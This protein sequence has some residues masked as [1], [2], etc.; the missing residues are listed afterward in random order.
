[1]SGLVGY[2]TLGTHQLRMTGMQFILGRICRQ[3]FQLF[4]TKKQITFDKIL[5]SYPKS[6]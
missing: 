2:Q 1:M 5:I 3:S 4:L 6:A